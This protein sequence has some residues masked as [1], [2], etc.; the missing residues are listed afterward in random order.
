[1]LN[2]PSI[3]NATFFIILAI[4]ILVIGLLVVYFESKNREQNHK[5]TS[6]LSLV[7]SLADELN[8]VKF[9]LNSMNMIGAGKRESANGLAN[10]INIPINSSE[11]INLGEK[12]IEVSD[13]DH[14]EDSEDDESEDDE[15]EEESDDE[16]EDDEKENELDDKQFSIDELNETDIK[17]LNFNNNTSKKDID[18]D[19]DN[20]KVDD[21]SD[22]SDDCDDCDDSDYDDD[23]FIKD[24]DD[25]NDIESLDIEEINLEN[26]L[27]KQEEEMKIFNINVDNLTNL[28]KV[29]SVE[30]TD[31]KKLSLAKLKSIVL[32]KG[33][34]NDSSKMK[35]N[36][37]LKILGCE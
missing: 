18:I 37:L 25:L 12:L 16:S 14:D 31:Y 28:E 34:V 2:T 13:D 24:D 32:E 35:K 1:M 6:M 11:S 23:D 19:I 30:V 20:K 5:I 9:H 29:K 21:D 4:F 10:S 3:F 7:S 33:L 8:A 26:N 15:S 17:I 36:D 22:D 27:T